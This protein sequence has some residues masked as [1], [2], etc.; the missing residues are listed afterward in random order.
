MTKGM[1][2]FVVVAAVFFGA[3]VPVAA[4]SG[5]E[6]TGPAPPSY[7]G[8]HDHAV[9]QQDALMIQTMSAP[10]ANTDAGFH[11]D[12]AQLVR[13]GDPSYVRDIEAHQFEIDRML[14]RPRG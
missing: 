10:T 1:R 4:Q 11:R 6:G 2:R 7:T 13:S 14:A 8:A 12:D 9:L 3:L 5:V